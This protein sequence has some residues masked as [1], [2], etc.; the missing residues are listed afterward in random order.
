MEDQAT[1]TGASVHDR[2]MSYLDPVEK[3]EIHAQVEPS[4]EIPTDEELPE[5]TD[6]KQ[7]DE[8][9][10]G[11]DAPT[12]EEQ[13]QVEL[14]KVASYL[15]L[16]ESA[17][18]VDENGELT[19]RTKIDGKDG[20]AKLA[21]LVKSYQLEGHLNKRNME[22]VEREKSLKA[23]QADLDSQHSAKLQQAE[24]LTALALQQLTGEFNSI[25]WQELRATDPGEYA[26][27]QAEYQQR[28]SNISQK[29]QQVQ[30]QRSYVDPE[31]MQQVLKE[32][33]VKLVDYIPAWSDPEI[34]AKEKGKVADYAMKQGYSQAQISKIYSASDVSMLYKA[35]KYDEL[36]Q[37][38]PTIKQKIVKAP[39]FV[40]AGQGVTAIDRA[41]RK[42][43]D[44]KEDV[45][46]NNGKN[47]SIEAYLLATGKV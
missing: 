13:P 47:G 42:V 23:Q 37:A 45:R 11:E 46:K 26:A 18:D 3:K 32:E 34:A 28:H 43:G 9:E 29:L 27:R 7:D 14:S 5:A 2:L 17:V 38:K 4:A 39:K 35:M 16:D 6:E 30:E 36:Q 20:H 24:D 10:E 40:K 12:E 19:F 15:G 8:S 22:V 44:L 21:D 41:S 33:N 31:K 25:N 1:Q